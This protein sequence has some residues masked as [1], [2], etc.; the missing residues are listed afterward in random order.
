MSK[1]FLKKCKLHTV[2]CF[3]SQLSSM[4]SEVTLCPRGL[5]QSS[6]LWSQCPLSTNPVM[7][8]P[9]IPRSRNARAL[10]STSKEAKGTINDPKRIIDF[11]VVETK[12][13]IDYT[14]FLKRVYI[15]C[16]YLL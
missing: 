7:V 5:C 2:F 11:K 15:L 1:S 8:T 14:I 16:M 6:L 10:T 3:F 9:N 4:D 12:I 13:K